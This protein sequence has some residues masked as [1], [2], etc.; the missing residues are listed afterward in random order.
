MGREPE[1]TFPQ[2]RCADSQ[3]TH[4]KT[5][6]ITNYQVNVSQNLSEILPHACQMA[7]IKKNTIDAD[8]VEKREFLYTVVRATMV[9]PL[10]E[11]VWIILQKAEIRTTI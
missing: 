3:Q 6:I 5:F 2:R 11:T 7:F 9:E 10:Q 1:E 8:N 4:K